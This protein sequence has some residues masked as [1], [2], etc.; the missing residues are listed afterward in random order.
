MII[1]L[2]V[3]CTGYTFDVAKLEKLEKTVRMV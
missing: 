2:L 3:A 1:F